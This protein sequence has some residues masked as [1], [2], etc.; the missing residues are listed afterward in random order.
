VLIIQFIM[1]HG[2]ILLWARIK[3]LAWEAI[4]AGYGD[5]L[6]QRGSTVRKEVR[7]VG[8]YQIRLSHSCVRLEAKSGPCHTRGM[9][10]FLDVLPPAPFHV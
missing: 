10:G 1:G 4:G 9:S 2:G 3:W 7:K 6:K 5:G 8:T